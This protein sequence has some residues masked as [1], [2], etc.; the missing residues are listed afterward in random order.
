MHWEIENWGKAVFAENPQH[1]GAPLPGANPF[2]ETIYHTNG[3][4]I[5]LL[6]VNEAEQIGSLY[7]LVGWYDKVIKRF[8][9][10]GDLP[11][12]VT[13]VM[14]RR[15]PI[16]INRMNLALD[17]LERN[18]PDQTVDDRNY[19]EFDHP[20]AIDEAVSRFDLDKIETI[21]FGRDWQLIKEP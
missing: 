16:L 4:E 8:F 18:L 12:H 7:A 5:G 2:R 10:S 21:S 20:D 3:G 13:H 1:S 17:E 15:I 19:L 6:T 14:L 9:D 11:A